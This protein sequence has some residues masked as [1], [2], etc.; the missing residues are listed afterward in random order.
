MA[1]TGQAE[2]GR[3]G[4]VKRSERSR[5]FRRLLEEHGDALWRL[6]A[7]YAR[8]RADREELRQKVCRAAWEA[9]PRLGRE[10]SART[11]LFRVVHN[12]G[13]TDGDVPGPGLAERDEAGAWP[14]DDGTATDDVDRRRG[15]LADAVREL[16]LRSRQAATLRLERL[17]HAGIADVLGVGANDVDVRLHRARNALESKLESSPGGGASAAGGGPGDPWDRWSELWRREEAPSDLAGAA[18]R[19]VRRETLKRTVYVLFE[20][21][22]AL[23]LLGYAGYRMWASPGAATVS[24]GV[25][26]WAFTL[27]AWA[28]SFWHRKRA[29]APADESVR[30]FL[31][32]S[33]Q[34]CRRD[35]RAVRF[36]IGLIAAEV[37][38]VAAWYAWWLTGGGDGE[39]GT[40][41]LALAA[42][43]LLLVASVLA[44]W[45][46][47][48]Q[49][50]ADERLRWIREREAE[51]AGEPG[52]PAGPPA[53]ES[54]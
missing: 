23:G 48:V 42:V 46:L 19:E 3:R 49:R 24:G 51:I 28:F 43:L 21:S 47:H 40:T 9:L 1:E 35:L 22:V 39:I 54:G 45:L 34:Y 44:G 30:R 18:T 11:G 16:P 7:A 41:T 12:R 13:L 15:R 6:T 5:R 17:S 20:A 38:S 27:T 52:P 10:A 37:A 14:P 31:A 4:A 2:A 36:G 33:R 26:V 32:M 29:W 50:R 8:G 53:R 25:A